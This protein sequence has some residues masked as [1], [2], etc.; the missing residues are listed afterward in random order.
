MHKLEHIY[1]NLRLPSSPLV[2]TN[3]LQVIGPPPSLLA[4]AATS[5]S[6]PSSQG[7][8]LTK[9]QA[10]MKKLVCFSNLLEIQSQDKKSSFYKPL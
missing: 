7:I 1:H 8:G 2:Q 6:V 9:E 10:K 5:F 4:T 3:F